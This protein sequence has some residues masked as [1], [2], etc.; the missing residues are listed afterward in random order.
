MPAALTRFYRALLFLYPASFRNEYGDELC[1]AFTMRRGGN[2]GVFGTIATIAAAITDVVPNAIAAHWDVLRQDLRYTLRGL[3]KAP[4]FAITAIL[5]VALGVGA[6]TAAFSVADFVLFRPL[7]FPQPERL[8]MLWE[9]TPGYQMELSPGNYADW[10]AQ[11]KSFSSMGAYFSDAVNLTGSGEPRRIEAARVT[12]DLFSTIGARA[13]AGRLFA[14]S[15]TVAGESL[16]ISHDLWQTQFGADPNVLGKSVQLDGRPHTI[17]GIMAPD[18]HFPDR[19]IEIWKTMQ[20]STEDLAPRNDNYIHVVGRLSSGVT[21][22]AARAELS[23]IA[24]RLEERFPAENKDTGAA[25]TRLSD[26]LSDRARL[27]LLALCGASLCILLLACANLGNLMLARA[28]SRERELAVRTA[29]GAGRERIVRQIVTE[30]ILLSTFGGIASVFVAFVAVPM[31]ARLV[32]NTL[33][34]AEQPAVDP[35][36]LVFA[37]F[38]VLITGLAFSLAPAVRASASTTLAG[39]RNDSRS[40]GG[41]RQ[42]VRSVL[43]IIEVMASVVLLISSGLLVRAM[44]RLQA[45]DP[46]FH[47]E[48]VLTANTTLPWPKYETPRAR[49]PFYDKVLGDLKATPGVQAAAYISFLPMVMRGGI[50]PVLMNGDEATRSSENTASLRFITPQFFRALQIPV[51]V[52]RGIDESDDDSRANVAVVSESFVEKYWPGE[53]PAGKRF[54]FAGRERTVVGVVGDIRVRGLEQTSEPQVYLPYKQVDSASL[55]GYVPKNLVVRSTLPATAL[56]PALR[57]I[58]HEADP[59]QP[60]SGV[61]TMEEIVANET[62]PRLAQLRVLMILATLALV[63]SAVGIHGLL[64]FTVSRRSREIGVRM[65]LGAESSSVRRMVMREGLLLAL[66]G[67]IPGVAVA[68]AAGRAMQALLVGVNPG[69]TATFATAIA[70]C[71]ATTVFGCFRPAQRAS[72]VDPMAALR[73]D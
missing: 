10:K 73:A 47:A 21:I 45:V 35:R 63:L 38:L 40:G 22:D 62:A 34:I 11:S 1:D 55:I 30:S 2:R 7:P 14:A 52:G 37:G 23:L 61:R 49:Q 43:V 56:V 65:A 12:W 31:L 46:G 48:N 42:R 26:Q 59:S 16:V 50:W 19:D 67:I 44:W 72:R 70:L 33:P 58:V 24:K 32:P 27:L 17:I 41:A 71:V 28:V 39:L 20:F 13:F 36:V 68:Y 57:R 29:L 5:V 18:F 15:D 54:T 69:D 3:R 6:N 4:G 64:S 9:R 8:M 53:T 60:I 51:K 25:I 66:A